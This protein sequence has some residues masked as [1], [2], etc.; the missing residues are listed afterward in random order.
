MSTGGRGGS[1]LNRAGHRARASALACAQRRGDDV[2]M[3]MDRPASVIRRG[4]P[5]RRRGHPRVGPDSR[6]RSVHLGDDRLDIR[7]TE[8]ALDRPRLV[9]PSER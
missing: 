2:G 7:L 9:L 8:P 1:D 4:R 6:R 5:L 3:R